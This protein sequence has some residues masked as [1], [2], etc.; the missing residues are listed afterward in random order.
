MHVDRSSVRE[1]KE[2]LSAMLAPSPQENLPKTSIPVIL[3]SI[4]RQG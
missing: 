2:T 3:C 1:R 4:L